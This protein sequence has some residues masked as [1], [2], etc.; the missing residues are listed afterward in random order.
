MII[1]AE[2]F[3]D[4]FK[5]KLWEYFYHIIIKLYLEIIYFWFCVLNS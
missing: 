5:S 3:F 1:D 2:E 4:V